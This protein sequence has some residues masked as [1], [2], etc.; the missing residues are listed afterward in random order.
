MFQQQ[1]D[2]DCPSLRLRCNSSPPPRWWCLCMTA[3]W[4]RARLVLRNVR[5]IQMGSS[6]STR[7]TRS[8]IR[9][10]LRTRSNS[11]W[12]L[13]R[14]SSSFRR[15]WICRPAEGELVGI[16]WAAGLEEVRIGPGE[17]RIDLAGDR[18]GLAEDRIGP[19]REG[20]RRKAGDA[21]DSLLRPERRPDSIPDWT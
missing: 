4:C 6:R 14:P 12:R 20:D 1:Q 19:G 13:D 3:G 15:P 21:G 2:S 5:R 17:V 7:S 16:A 8:S 11:R 10:P 9:T 18:I